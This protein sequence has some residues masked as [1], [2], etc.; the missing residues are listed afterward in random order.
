MPKQIIVYQKQ[1]SG[2]NTNELQ[3]FPGSA[4]SA[5]ARGS[6]TRFGTFFWICT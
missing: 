5:D 4:Y 3:R 2:S 6:L 1:Y